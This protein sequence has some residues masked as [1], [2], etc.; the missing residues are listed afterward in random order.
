M[1]FDYKCQVHLECKTR[2]ENLSP[3]LKH[4]RKN[5]ASSCVFP[6][7]WN[8]KTHY[9]CTYEHNNF[10]LGKPWCSTKVDENDNHIDGHW[11]I[12]DIKN[13]KCPIEEKP[14]RTSKLF[15]IVSYM[16]CFVYNTIGLIA[17][18]LTPFPLLNRLWQPC[19]HKAKLH[20]RRN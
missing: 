5:M 4:E 11:G 1:V 7:T 9:A 20:G 15:L 19:S 2:W 13:D 3:A 6:F 16:A 17:D 18:L 14:Q 12:C 8:N 10:W